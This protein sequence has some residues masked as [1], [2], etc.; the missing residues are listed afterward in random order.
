MGQIFFITFVLFIVGASSL[1][2]SL[3]KKHD[4]YQV[5]N[6]YLLFLL[7]LL[8]GSP[9][10]ASLTTDIHHSLRLLFFGFMLFIFS[11]YGANCIF[12]R[13][14]TPFY[15]YIV[16]MILIVGTLF[17]SF[18]YFTDYF[19]KNDGY[20]KRS[21]VW[22]DGNKF[23]EHVDIAMGE[24]L[25]KTVY[26]FENPHNPFYANVD[27]YNLKQQNEKK[28]IMTKKD[29]VISRSECMI[30]PQRNIQEFILQYKK[31]RNDMQVKFRTDL[32]TTYCYR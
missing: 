13:Y 4:K 30:V 1:V 2:R 3:L 32:F 12:K 18:F 9:I 26:L 23:E 14:E 24:S 28:V 15:A 21:T 17:Q 25:S 6:K 5:E 29:S 22:F 16:F 11:L 20:E 27:F 19:N 10:A 7:L 8:I 31:K